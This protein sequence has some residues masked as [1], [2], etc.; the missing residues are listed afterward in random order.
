MQVATGEL[1]VIKFGVVFN[2]K[3]SASERGV[4]LNHLNPPAY[5]LDM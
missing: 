2:F 5:A 3:I 1:R 4:R